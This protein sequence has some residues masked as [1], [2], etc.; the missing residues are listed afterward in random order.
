MPDT[1]HNAR[2]LNNDELMV[3][4]H[5]PNG[6]VVHHDFLIHQPVESLKDFVAPR[7]GF[8]A[9]DLALMVRNREL[10]TSLSTIYNTEVRQ[11]GLLHISAIYLGVEES[12]E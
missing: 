1:Q 12:K 4:F 6:R 8:P 11:R 3:V 7:A 9:R 5:L 2:N 10:N